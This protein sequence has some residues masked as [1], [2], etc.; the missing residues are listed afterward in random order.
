ML[1]APLTEDKVISVEGENEPRDLTAIEVLSDLEESETDESEKSAT[2]PT[3]KAWKKLSPPKGF[4]VTPENWEAACYAALEAKHLLMIGPTGSGK[5][6]LSWHVAASTG[7]ELEPFNFGAMSEAR[8]ALIGSTHLSTEKGTYFNESRFVRAVQRRGMLLW[9]EITRAPEDAFNIILPLMDRQGYLALDES[10]PSDE[11]QA[12]EQ[13]VYKSPDTVF[14]A[15]ANVG[16]EYTGTMAMDRA[17][18]D[19]FPVILDIGYPPAQDETRVLSHR[20]K[21]LKKKFISNITTVA[22]TQRG[23]AD[24]GEFSRKISTR[25][26]LDCGEAVEAGMSESTAIITSILNKFDGEGAEE[27]ERFRVAAAFQK[28]NLLPEPKGGV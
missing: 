10:D 14:F 9:D 1:G 26:L 20:C 15:T 7:L 27:S 12:A 2:P 23:M 25:M 8:T 3:I 4:Y 6:E 22:E 5:S 18:L 19:R 13:V 11:T 21:K 24:E 16:V 17:L 28:V